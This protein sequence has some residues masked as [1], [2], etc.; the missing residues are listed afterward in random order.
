M[1]K[2]SIYL[3]FF[4]NDTP[5][6][7]ISPLSLHNALP[8]S[9]APAAYPPTGALQPASSAASRLR[10]AVVAA[11]LAVSSTQASSAVSSGWPV[12]HS[13]ARAPWPRSEEHT[14]ELQSPCNLVCRLLLE[15]K[16]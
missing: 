11:R 9:S 1:V 4:L 12:R 5:P 14:S 7:E 6:T 10:S 3:F 16:T 15:K 13:T 2:Q 8:I